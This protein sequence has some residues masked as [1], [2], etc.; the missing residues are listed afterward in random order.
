M[1]V[2]KI[3]G[4]CLDSGSLEMEKKPV[5]L[6]DWRTLVEVGVAVEVEAVV[7]FSKM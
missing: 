3:A 2:L 7:G 5:F 6:K 1:S 4:D